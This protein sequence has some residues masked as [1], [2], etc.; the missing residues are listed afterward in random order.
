MKPHLLFPEREFDFEAPLPPGS[1]DVVTDL[2]LESLVEAMAAGDDFIAEV[3][4]PV[5]MSSLI[6]CTTIRYRQSVLADC[7]AHAD[8]IRELYQVVLDAQEERRQAWAWSVGYSTSPGVTLSTALRALEAAVPRLRQLRSLAQSHGESFRSEGLRRMC[9]EL[10]TELDDE[11]FRRVKDHLGHL[12]FRDGHLLS[13]KLAWDNSGKDYV[14]RS[15]GR[16]PPRWRSRMRAS[17]TPSYAFSVDPRDEAAGHALAELTDRG[18]NLVANAVARSADHVSAYFDALRSELAFYLGCVNLHQRLSARDRPICFP[19]PSP[20]GSKEMSTSALCDTTLALRTDGEVVDN[21][22]NADG[23]RLVVI[24]GANSGGKSTFLRSVGLA[25]LMMQCG[26]FVAARAYRAG[27]SEGIFTHFI[28]E[29]DT[30]MD[31]GRL[32]EELA[33]MSRIVDQLRPNGLV[34]F[35]E[36]FAGTNEREGSEIA[37]QVVR[38]LLE[39][40]V[41]V[42]FVTHQF[43]FAESCRLLP[44]TLFLRAERTAGGERNYKIR[45]APPLPTSFG[46]DLYARVGHWLGEDAQPPLSTDAT[47]SV[48]AEEEP[49]S[50]AAPSFD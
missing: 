13:A 33:R 17:R 34:L 41:R 5:L 18:V 44:G 50:R 10:R 25:Q 38:A 19:T 35:N 48:P 24:T 42:A 7:L 40:S 11:Y 16:R 47:P 22:L 36:S 21:D 23:H 12:R 9:Q 6:D 26:M 30:S 3:S 1:Q 43:D 45:E 27:I 32:D 49:E 28:R 15:P 4:L 39:C 37:R 31:S 8:V 2:Y 29:E 20:L 46:Q 14:L